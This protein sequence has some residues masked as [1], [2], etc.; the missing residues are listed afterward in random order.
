L[1]PGRDRGGDDGIIGGSG[2]DRGVG[3]GTEQM[4]AEKTEVGR[5]M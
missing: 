5:Y 4:M 1:W 2:V 3:G